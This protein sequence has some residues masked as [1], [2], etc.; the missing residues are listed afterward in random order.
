MAN[1]GIEVISRAYDLLKDYN[2]NNGYII[3]L[4]NKVYAYQSITLN[5]FQSQFVIENYDFEPKFIG[6]NVKIASWWAEKKQKELGLEFTPK[7]MEI[8][9]YMGQANGIYVFYSRFRKS[10]EKG[11]LTI[12][13]KDAILTDFLTEDYHQLDVDFDRYDRLASRIDPNRKI[14]DAQKESIKFLLSR[15]KCILADDMGF[16]KMEPVDSLIPTEFGFKRMGDINVGDRVYNRYGQLT[17]V[18]KTYNHK[19]KD[20]YKVKF[21]DKTECEC[22]LEHLWVVRDTNMVSR[23]KG[24]KTMSLQEILNRGIKYKNGV[25]KFQIPVCEPVNYGEKEYIIPPYMLGVIIGDGN[26]CNG[27]IHISIPDTEYETHDR[28]TNLLQEGYTLTI[29]RSTSCP[30]HNIVK[31]KDNLQCENVYNREIKRLGLNIHGNS[32]FIPTEYKLGSIEQRIELLRGLMDSDGT[33]SKTGNKI[34]YCTNSKRLAED[35]KELVYSLGGE[36]RIRVCDRTNKGRNIEYSVGIQIKI[37]PFHLER[38][39]ERYNPT[40]KKDC[41][42]YIESVEFSRKSDAKCLAVDSPCH[43]YLTG[44]SYIVTHN[45]LSLS[46]AAIEGNFDSVIIMCPASI[47]TN[48]KNELSYYTDEKYISVI[49]SFNDKSKSEL[50]KFLGYGQNKSGKK[51]EELLEEAKLEGKWQDNKFVI[52]NFDIIDEFYKI[53]GRVKNVTDEMINNSPMLKY[54]LNKKSLLIIDEAHKL[55]NKDSI[56]YKVIQGLI[57]RGKPHS[58]YLATGTPITNSP[59]NLYHV[60]KLIGHPVT[61]DYRKYMERYCGAKKI[62]HPKDRDKRNAISNRYINSLGKHT[63]YD[64][65]D[66]EKGILQSMI[67]SKC[68]MMT[69]AQE[70]TNL[71]ELKERISTIYLR[72]TKD[73]INGLVKKHVHEMFYDLTPEQELEYN[74]LWEEYEELKRQEDENKEINKDLLEGAVY[75]KYISNITVPYTENIVD[76]LLRRGEKVVIAC[77][78]DEELYTLKEYYGDKAVVYNGKMSLKQKDEAINKFYNNQDVTV[79]IGNIIAAGVGINL[80]NARYMVFNNIDYVPGNDRQMEDRI[81]RITQKRECHIV[82]QIFRNTQYENI[83]NTVMKKELVIGQIIKKESEK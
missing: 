47:K 6:K 5:D 27:G 44:K 31:T 39:R 45:T 78:Y 58:I 30:R 80:V 43:T 73:E 20:I 4:K 42:K 54:I 34:S 66:K 33:I 23:G 52:V 53:G 24:W 59:Q 29:D 76:K 49:D 10:Q 38:K 46:V 25:N 15:K 55:S 61:D 19:N 37:N 12:C 81:W 83:W 65:T 82:Y 32:K 11:L 17:T 3:E 36:A 26:L 9:Y 62:C 63:W 22:G 67:E 51:K 18:L 13:T 1:S 56:R 68:R 64:L 2:G 35:V 41:V 69:V 74:K 16:G 40:F 50:E 75:R 60:L 48:W 70:G 77:C 79:F 57:K 14:K 7:L 8:G 72:R 21:S 28:L 71:D